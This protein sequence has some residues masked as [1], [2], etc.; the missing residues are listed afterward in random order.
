MDEKRETMKK[1]YR[2]KVN[3]YIGG[4]AGGLADYFKVDVNLFRILFVILTFFGGLGLILY[5]VALII[6]PENPSQDAELKK[7]SKDRTVFWALLLIAI[8]FL[9]LEPRIWLSNLNVTDGYPNQFL[10]SISG[11]QFGAKEIC[12]IIKLKKEI[13]EEYK[14][15]LDMLSTFNNKRKN[16]RRAFKVDLAYRLMLRDFLRKKL[17]LLSLDKKP[18]KKIWA[19]STS[20]F[21]YTPR[22][23]FEQY[24]LDF[25][26]H[27]CT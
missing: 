12:E 1:M 21:R 18:L 7:V 16:F 3:R 26:Q 10:V 5:I 6:V 17:Y 9:L 20:I 25:T 2:S 15:V 11:P 24:I 22:Q 13:Q 27:S 8:G 19:R 23:F 4:V 14:N